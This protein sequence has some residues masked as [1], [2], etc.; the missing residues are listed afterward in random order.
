MLLCS[1]DIS[2]ASCSYILEVDDTPE[3]SPNGSVDLILGN[4]TL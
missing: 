2:L 4:R 3:V 1:W